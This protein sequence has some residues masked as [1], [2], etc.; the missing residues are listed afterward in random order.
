VSE[1]LAFRDLIRRLRLG[2]ERAAAELVTEHEDALRRIVRVRLR[3]SRLRRLLDSVD[4]CQ[5]V[6]CAFFVRAA[7]GQ[8]ELHDPDQLVK[9]LA[10]MARN[11]LVNL[12]H[13]HHAARRDCRRVE[14]AA[15]EERELPISAFDPCRL[16][17]ARDLLAVARRC[18]SGEERR[19]LE[20]RQQ[21]RDWAEIAAE[22][23]GSPEALRKQ[24]A[25]AVE[26]VAEELGLDEVS[27]DP[28]GE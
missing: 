2:D 14:G 9:L 26:R 1:N 10:R 28:G 24:L 8:F 15:V 22:V 13:K 4:V 11:K 3:D 19:L 20:L 16:A 12:W 7:L 25:R 23:G 18:L 27:H 5:S 17:T 21:G 6:L